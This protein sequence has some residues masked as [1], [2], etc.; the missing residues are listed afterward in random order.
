[1]RASI[2]LFLLLIFQHLF[3]TKAQALDILIY[4]SNYV[5]TDSKTGLEAKGYTVSGSTSTTVASASTLANYD[6]VFDQLYNNNCGSTCRANY[7]TYVK[8][9]GTL[10]IVGENSNFSSRNNTVIS[11]IENKF[12]GTLDLG[13]NVSGGATYS[14]ADNTVNTSISG[15]DDG[16]QYIYGSSI[17]NTSDGVWVAKSGGGAVIWMMWRGSSLPSGYT[18]SVIVTFDINQFDDM[19]DTSETWEFVDDVI[20]YGI[21]GEMESSGTT[22]TTTT[23]TSSGISGGQSTQVTTDRARAA[24]IKS[25]S[26]ASDNSVYIEQAGDSNTVE[27]L[28]DGS[29]G[30]HI[31]GIGQNMADITGDSNDLEIKQGAGTSGDGVNLIELMIDGDT[32]D[33]KLY[34]DRYDDGTADADPT[35]DHIIKLNVDG[36]LNDIEVIQRSNGTDGHYADIDV[37][38]NSSNFDILQKGQHEKQLFID[39]TGNSNIIDVEQRDSTSKFADI[40][41][42]GDGHDVTVLQKGTGAHNA[43][44]DLTFGSGASTVDL[45]QQGT[46]NQSYSLEQICYNV[47]GCSTTVTQE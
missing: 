43:T 29:S 24:T 39:V 13:S 34:Q 32:N 2:L 9:G 42:T 8:D 38:G 18:G 11:L 30:N 33:L 46:S 27:I 23:G 16:G 21:N 3:A 25:T 28:Q 20:Y 12:G 44:I 31:R 22:T 35:G 10:V 36:N 14:T 6:I 1:M 26:G 17:A 40:K 5:Y 45:T 41:L 4:H 15:T 19:Y 7:D 47:S 37:T